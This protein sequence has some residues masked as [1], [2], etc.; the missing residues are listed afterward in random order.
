MNNKL[1]I[2]V[3]TLIVIFF[4]LSEIGPECITADIG[5]APFS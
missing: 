1:R 5:N 2:K 3:L 4:L